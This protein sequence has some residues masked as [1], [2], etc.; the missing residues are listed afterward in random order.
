MPFDTTGLRRPDNVVHLPPI[1]PDRGRGRPRRIHIDIVDR[2][3]RPTTRSRF[4]I[5]KLFV[6][7]LIPVAIFG[8]A[9]HAQPS[10]WNSYPFGSGTNYNGMDAKGGQWS[11]RSY[12]MGTTTFFDA[13]GPDG[14]HRHC[15]SY[16]VGSV[17]HTICD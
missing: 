6:A 13:D 14:Q 12:D 3:S 10:I 7:L 2:R 9:A 11:G 8:C 17:T 15:Q 1:A 16:M 4:V 5:L